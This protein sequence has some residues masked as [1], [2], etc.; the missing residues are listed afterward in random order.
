M[1]SAID[2]GVVDLDL[3]SP[4]G[5]TTRERQPEE[6][7]L[8]PEE[9]DAFREELESLHNWLLSSIARIEDAAVQASGRS[10]AIDDGAAQ[11]ERTIAERAIA[12]KRQLLHQVM[13]A[14]ERIR[15]NTYGRCAADNR[16]ISRSMLEE[17]PWTQYCARCASRR[18]T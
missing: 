12:N 11:W 5:R 9:I 3:T 13:G 15:E 17:V 18:Q 7:P 6:P 10:V 16:H 4:Y 8:T 14:F 2:K 1:D